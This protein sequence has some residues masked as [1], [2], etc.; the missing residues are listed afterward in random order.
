MSENLDASKEALK[1]IA[2]AGLIAKYGEGKG[3]IY[4]QVL[5]GGYGLRGLIGDA[6]LVAK[7]L[8]DDPNDVAKNFT[9]EAATS[10][11]LDLGSQA[12]AVLS[13]KLGIGSEVFLG[14]V[15]AFLTATAP[16]KI[17][18][19]ELPPGMKKPV[20]KGQPHPKAG[21]DDEPKKAKDKP[22]PNPHNT[23]QPDPAPP[24]VPEEP[25]PAPNPHN[26]PKPD[27]GPPKLPKEPPPAPNPH[28]KPK[29]TPAPPSAPK[30]P[31]PAPSP[32]NKATPTPAPPTVEFPKG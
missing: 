32:H 29:P 27:Y 9:Q 18:D 13:A 16:S 21:A 19:Q 24:S 10:L 7:G 8:T 4:S 11:A 30:E 15:G 3:Q 17:G 23:P 14:V 20:D 6:E 25:T 5:F 26:E 31:P 12:I 1:T 2:T 22:A 28:N